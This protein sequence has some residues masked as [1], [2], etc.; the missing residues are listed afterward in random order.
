M[1]ANAATGKILL[2]GQNRSLTQQIAT[3][4]AEAGWNLLGCVE[5]GF[6]ALDSLLQYQP[7]LVLLDIHLQGETDGIETL[8]LMKQYSS[9]AVILYGSA[10]EYASFHAAMSY[11][12]ESV[13]LGGVDRDKLSLTVGLFAAKLKS[14]GQAKPQSASADSELD[15]IS[16]AK[17]RKP[18]Q[19]R[20]V[21]DSRRVTGFAGLIG[22][23]AKMTELYENIKLAASADIPVFLEGETGTGKELVAAAIHKSGARADKPF[24]AINCGALTESIAESELFGH[25]KGSFTG[26]FKSR[27]GKIEAAN[28]GTIFLDEIC[29]L[30]LA[31]QVK[32]LRVLQENCLERV[33]SNKL[34][35]INV[36]IICATNKN[37]RE[38]IKAGRFREDLYYRICVMHLSLPPLRERDGDLDLL[39]DHF[40]ND[41]NLLSDQQP[42]FSREASQALHRY[43]WPG[44]VRELKNVMQY[45]ILKSRGKRIELQHLPAHFIGASLI[46][47]ARNQSR[48]HRKKKLSDSSVHEKLFL[49]SGNKKEAARLLGVSR[50]TLYRFLE[51]PS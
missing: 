45:A 23:N 28:N 49:T 32:L 44:N 14:K 17:V 51:H 50:A 35:P 27:Q 33:G 12:P 1:S 5:S 42:S 11:Q 10:E 36:R 7:D 6:D 20:F 48:L 13:I 26:A 18:D 41:A 25:E 43:Q 2:V 16:C 38:E 22:S 21:R 47:E 3:F 19:V 8:R 4:L 15:K 46:S 37:I 9:A 34:V 31:V 39:I 40:L 24:I 30:S 29:E